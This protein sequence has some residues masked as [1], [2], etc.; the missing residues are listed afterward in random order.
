MPRHVVELNFLVANKCIIHSELV[1][2]VL[3]PK[4]MLFPSNNIFV[5]LYVC[6][7]KLWPWSYNALTVNVI[8]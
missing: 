3:F 8:H 2:L 6:Y 7:L 1:L 4:G 5:R